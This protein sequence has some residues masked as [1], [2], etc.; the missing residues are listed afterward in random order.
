MVTETKKK[1]MDASL[2]IALV[3]VCFI[4]CGCEETVQQEPI[5]KS[6]VNTMQINMLN[7]I[8]MENAIVTQCTLYPYH[9]IN[10]SHQLNELG[11]K[12][13]S[14]LI[15]RFKQYPGHLNVQQGDTL[16][17]VYQARV[18]YVYRQLENAG[19]DMMKVAIADEMPGGS[20]MSTDDVVE[21]QQADRKARTDRREKFP[22]ISDEISN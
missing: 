20:G 12:D 4:L 11:H 13:L 10:N 15:D 21:I 18:A 19:I 9:F 7:D 2:L 17:S 16:S 6:L 5:D 3:F 1:I 22:R 14:I 8:A